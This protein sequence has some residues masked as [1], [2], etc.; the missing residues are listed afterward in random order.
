[1]ERASANGIF[2]EACG[3]CRVYRL[4]GVNDALR[5]KIGAAIGE[6]PPEL[7]S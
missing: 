5:A 2:R 6:R 1:M 3:E 4:Y 7:A